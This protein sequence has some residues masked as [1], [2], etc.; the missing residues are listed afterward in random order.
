MAFVLE[1]L[2]EQD[3]EFIASFKFIQPIGGQGKV[4][5]KIPNNWAADR[6][7][8]IFLV[9]L[10]GQGDSFDEEY[11]PFYYRLIWNN[12][13]V[14]I[15]ARYESVGNYTTGVSMTWRIHRIVVPKSLAWVHTVLFTKG[16]TRWKAQ[17][18]PAA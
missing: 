1:K 17:G 3:K 2:T 18:S 5:A 16:Y 13:A 9:C 11:P 14:N 10:G 6:E 4:L 15:E 12:S 7:R 8:K